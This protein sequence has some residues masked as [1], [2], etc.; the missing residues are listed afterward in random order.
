MARWCLHSSL[1]ALLIST[2][3]L[4]GGCNRHELAGYRVDEVFDDPA[5]AAFVH[6][7][8]DEDEDRLRADL[9]AGV[10]VNAQGRDGLTPLMWA[11]ASASH[12]GVRRLLEAGA[13]PNIRTAKGHSA[14]STALVQADPDLLQLL[15]AHSGD[16]NL[17]D[18]DNKPLLH[19][20]AI[21][22]DKVKI[23][24][25]LAA[26]A[27][28]NIRNKAGESAMMVA[29]TFNQYDVILLLIEQ[30]ADIHLK[31]N[32]GWTLAHQVQNQN[33]EI[34]IERTRKHRMQVIEA[35][36]QRGIRFPIDYPARKP[37]PWESGGSQKKLPVY[38][39]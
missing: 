18:P 26:S 5:L 32:F 9:A 36:E 37:M 34:L 7:L 29:E 31:D 14:M 16:P 35:L 20:L 15:L 4:I 24:R 33:P 38:Y 39:K 11:V 19:K 8:L 17:L 27:D 21:N 10:N 3:L 1:F 30:G 23:S 2:A 6:H 25:L 22:G 12:Y 13:N 28:I